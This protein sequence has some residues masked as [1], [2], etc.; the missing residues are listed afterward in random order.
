MRWDELLCV[1]SSPSPFFSFVLSFVVHSFVFVFLFIS[2]HHQRHYAHRIFIHLHLPSLSPP[3]PHR[4]HTEPTPHAPGSLR[5]IDHALLDND[6]VLRLRLHVHTEP[7]T[8]N[9]A[10]KKKIKTH[11]QRRGA[12]VEGASAFTGGVSGTRPSSTTLPFASSPFAVSTACSFLFAFGSFVLLL[13]FVEAEVGEVGEVGESASAGAGRI[14][15]ISR[16]N[17]V[18]Q[19]AAEYFVTYCTQASALNPMK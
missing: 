2:H 14:F 7:R 17:D 9:N 5:D 12:A 18:P 16:T 3:T 19:N 15:V 11:R 4:F 1:F 8:A 6:R 13:L 10:R